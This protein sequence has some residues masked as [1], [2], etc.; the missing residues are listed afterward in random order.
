MVI[1]DLCATLRTRL[2]AQDPLLDEKQAADFLSMSPGML[3]VWRATRRYD[4]P[5]VKVGRSVR[6]RLSDLQAFL[7][8]RTVSNGDARGKEEPTLM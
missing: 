4:L 8:A 2:D 1:T 6:Y 3:S 5:F 7:D